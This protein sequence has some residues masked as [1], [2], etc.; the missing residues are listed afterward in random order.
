[1]LQ[2]QA[3]SAA[4]VRSTARRFARLASCAQTGSSC[5]K[6]SCHFQRFGPPPLR[7]R[8]SGELA[9]FSV[10]S[11]SPLQHHVAATTLHKTASEM[12]LRAPGRSWPRLRPSSSE[13]G[14]VRVPHV[15][16]LLPHLHV[17]WATSNIWHLRAAGESNARRM[18]LRGAALHSVVRPHLA[19]VLTARLLLRPGA[20]VG[21]GYRSARLKRRSSFWLV[22]VPTLG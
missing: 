18:L 22:R 20:A 1:M 9:H 5:V 13:A 12:W 7:R 14:E 10:T 19:V 16:L 15:L 2:V 4:R 17:T 3:A 21:F 8:H 11:A 6:E